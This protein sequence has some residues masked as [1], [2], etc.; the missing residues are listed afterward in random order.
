MKLRVLSLIL[1]ESSLELVP[2]AIASH[3]SVLKTARRRG[4]RPSD[5]VLDVSLHYQAMRRLRQRHK[6]G[7][8]DIVHVVLLEALSSPLNIEGRLHIYI[9]TISDYVIR[10][11]P[12]TR[13]PR[14]Y[15]RFIGLM[16]QLLKE[17]RVPP[18]SEEPLMTAVSMSFTSLIEELGVEGV[19]ALSERGELARLS[20]ICVKALDEGL[21]V[22]V[23]GFPHGDFNEEVL[24]HAKYVYSIYPKPLDAWVVVSRIIST[25]EKHLKIL[26]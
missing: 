8:P 12:L 13:V 10:I 14:N 3:P 1:A 15:N 4:K 23:G 20:D 25:C 26:L 5:L 19:I 17:G 11:N 7:R 6:R 22:V 24:A 16:E 18:N 2:N 21:P 9:H